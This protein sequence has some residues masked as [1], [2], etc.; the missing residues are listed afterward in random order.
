MAAAST[1]WPR[2]SPKS[3]PM[4]CSRPGAWWAPRWGWWVSRLPGVAAAGALALILV[5]QWRA[6]GPRTASREL[7]RFVLML[8]P[9]AA[10][11]YLVMG[12]VWPWA[13]EHPL[14]PVVATEYFSHF[15]EKPWKEV[16]D[17]VPL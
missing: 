11:A 7:G 14:N 8:L 10:L 3:R 12:L 16:F 17:G 2:W 1:C 15:F 13:I 9:G 5:A 6:V 4:T